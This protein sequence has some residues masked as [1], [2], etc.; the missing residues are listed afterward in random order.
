MSTPLAK[1]VFELFGKPELAAEAESK[2]KEKQK[3]SAPP[4]YRVLY[5][6]M[7]KQVSEDMPL[8]DYWLCDAYPDLW[9]KIR[10]LDNALT[11]ME[12]ATTP[13]PSQTPPAKRVA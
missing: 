4:D 9:S 1:K 2:S 8:V 11:G 7:T 13:E 10:T 5:E 12:Q 6:E 3:S